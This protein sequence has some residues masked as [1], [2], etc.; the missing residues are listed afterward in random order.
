MN[1]TIIC[2]GKLKEQYLTDAVKEYSKRISAFGKLD[3]IEL[4]P[5]KL[6]ENP[7]ESEI[8]VALEKEAIEIIKKTPQNAF[9]IPLCVEGDALSSE[10]L[11][12]KFNKI[13]LVS[14]F[15][16]AIARVSADIIVK[17]IIIDDIDLESRKVT[18]MIKIQY[19]GENGEY[20]F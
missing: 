8:K 11:A 4:T 3:I 15:K 9:L 19:E 18:G 10:E 16:K 6:S 20:R 2:L 14:A 7:S 5:I 13:R 1:I 17:D 12:H